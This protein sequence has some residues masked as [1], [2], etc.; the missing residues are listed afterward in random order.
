MSGYDAPRNGTRNF[1][2]LILLNVAY[3]VDEYF[4]SFVTVFLIVNLWDK[5]PINIIPAH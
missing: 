5:I 3:S 4:S 2:D 1:L